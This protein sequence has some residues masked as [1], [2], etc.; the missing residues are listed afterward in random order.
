[1][2]NMIISSLLL[3]AACASQE[4]KSATMTAEARDTIIPVDFPKIETPKPE[5]TTTQLLL[6]GIRPGTELTR[7]QLVSYFQVDT[8]DY[9]YRNTTSELLSVFPLG[10]SLLIV[11][12]GQHDGNCQLASVYI[13]NRYSFNKINEKEIEVSCDMDNQSSDQ[14]SY[15]FTTNQDFVI[16]S[17]T[18]D[19][20]VDSDGPSV[21]KKEYWSILANGQFK[22]NRSESSDQP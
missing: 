20:G 13:I 2:K 10:D 5:E 4:N 11:V 7:L 8:M 1:M 14:V 15:Q 9:R 17:A 18:Y 6:D 3:L 19:K 21:T 16:T 12:A 22:K